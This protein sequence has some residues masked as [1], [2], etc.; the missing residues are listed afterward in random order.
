MAEPSSREE[1]VTTAVNREKTIIRT[2]I[3]GILANVFLAAAVVVKLVLG[4]YTKSRG[5]KV[6]SGSLVA[7]GQDAFQD[8]ILSASVL[9]SAAVY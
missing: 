2:S 7:S 8:A 4:A 3:L 1:L 6:N 5:K 9:V